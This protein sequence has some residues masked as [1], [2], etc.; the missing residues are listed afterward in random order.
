MK[1][2]QSVSFLETGNETYIKETSTKNLQTLNLA[3]KLVGQLGAVA[4]EKCGGT[5]DQH[6][7]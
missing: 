1:A 7:Q 5:N 6:P 4:Y 2:K 3:K